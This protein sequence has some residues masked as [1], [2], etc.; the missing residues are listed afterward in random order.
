MKL[1]SLLLI[2]LIF[3]FSSGVYAQESVQFVG[4]TPPAVVGRNTVRIQDQ[5]FDAAISKNATLKQLLQSMSTIRI[6]EENIAQRIQSR[7]T[8]ESLEKV[9]DISI[10]NGSLIEELGSVAKTIDELA[11][12]P[13]SSADDPKTAYTDYRVRLTGVVDQLH[14]ILAKEKGIVSEMKSIQSKTQVVQ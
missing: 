9:G 8:K 13:Y 12:N 4:T 3:F 6:R 7:I 5:T 14:D 10:R 1:Q 2:S 11:L